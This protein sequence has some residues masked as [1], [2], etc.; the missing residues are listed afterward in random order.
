MDEG[1]IDK[2]WKSLEEIGKN[3]PLAVVTA[4]DQKFAEHF[5]FD[6]EAIEKAVK[7]NDKHKGKKVNADQL[8]YPHYILTRIWPKCFLRINNI[9]ISQGIGRNNANS[10]KHVASVYYEPGERPMQKI[11]NKYV[12]KSSLDSNYAIWHMGY[13]TYRNDID[14][15]FPIKN[16]CAALVDRMQLLLGE[17]KKV[18][19]GQLSDKIQVNTIQNSYEVIMYGESYTVSNMLSYYIYRELPSISFI[20]GGMKHLDKNEAFVIIKHKNYKDLLKNAGDAI[21]SDLQAISAAF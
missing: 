5:G 11:D 9:Y 20:T 6:L 14:L 12:G 19:D 17:W 15:R 16:A 10:F 1:K 8:M 3:M 21:I 18:N 2:D 13:T 7:Y 4:E